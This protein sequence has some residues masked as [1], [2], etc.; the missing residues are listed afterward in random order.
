MFTHTIAILQKYQTESQRVK[1]RSTSDPLDV[2]VGDPENRIDS[3][4]M[5]NTKGGCANASS[6]FVQP[7][8]LYQSAPTPCLGQVLATLRF[9]KSR[10]H[11]TPQKMIKR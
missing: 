5:K 9:S 2:G 1:L 4:S 7:A 3:R 8:M 6:N 11:T 10:M